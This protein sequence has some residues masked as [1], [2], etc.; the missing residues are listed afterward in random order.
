MSLQE[1]FLA[2]FSGMGTAYFEMLAYG[3]SQFMGGR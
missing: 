2:I 3:I 1:F